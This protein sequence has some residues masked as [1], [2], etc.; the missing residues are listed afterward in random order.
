MIEIDSALLNDFVT[1]AGEHLEEMESVLMRLAQDPTQMELLNEVFR[2]AH[3]IKGASQFMGLDKI[4]A[5]S[6][7]S[8]DLLDLL[9][10]GEKSLNQAM[11]DTLIETKDRI[12]LLVNELTTSQTEQSEVDDLIIRIGRLIDDSDP[13]E[14]LSLE[15]LAAAADDQPHDVDIDRLIADS[16]REGS[17]ATADLALDQPDTAVQAPSADADLDRLIEASLSDEAQTT[18]ELS[19]EQLAALAEQQ[20]DTEDMDR[21]VQASLSDDAGVVAEASSSL[22]PQAAVPES[23]ARSELLIETPIDADEEEYDQELFQ[24]FL[25]LLQQKVNL[26]HYQADTWAATDNPSEGLDRYLDHLKSLESAANY[27]GYT[28]LIALYQGWEHAIQERRQQVAL[29]HTVSLVVAH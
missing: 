1:E 8:E 20:A 5:L 6:H 2:P 21:L 27:M 3:T 13:T 22:P 19:F 14:D 29:G 11:L 23:P 9:R 16:L 17:D 25:K 18:D 4:A 12:A 10:R 15:Q 24:I 26:L 28:Q 7:K